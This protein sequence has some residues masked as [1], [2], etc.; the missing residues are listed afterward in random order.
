M[1]NG[2]AGGQSVI[3]EIAIYIEG[4][5]DSTHGKAALRLGFD[6]LL[7]RQKAAA[8]DRRMG[9][10]LVLCGGREQA[11]H[12]FRHSTNQGSRGAAIGLLV[13][14]EG[15]V[16]K[17]DPLG[18]VAHLRARDKWDCSFADVEHVHLMTQTM[19]TWLVADRDAVLKFYGKGFGDKLPRRARLDEEPKANVLSALENSTKAT[20]K[21]TYGKI[22]HASELL[23]KCDPNKIAARCDSFRH[24]VTWLDATIAGHSAS[25]E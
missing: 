4:G 22:T 6:A 8:R 13:D 25:T 3:T 5:G 14:A 1:E 10:K 23:K 12:M 21:G 15:P 2:R 11:F 9:W 19:E 7:S 20:Q 18:R 17:A 16:T 24:F